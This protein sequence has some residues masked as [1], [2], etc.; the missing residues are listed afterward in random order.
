VCGAL[1]AVLAAVALGLATAAA[2]SGGRTGNKGRFCFTAGLH[3]W[4]TLQ[5]VKTK[6]Q[7]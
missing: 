5:K 4:R 6:F 2:G 1:L 3:S 7:F